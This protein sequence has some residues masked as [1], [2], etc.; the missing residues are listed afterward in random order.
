MGWRC[1]RGGCRAGVKRP[2]RGDTFLFEQFLPMLGK[3]GLTGAEIRRLT[4]ENPA[5]AFT[6]RRRPKSGQA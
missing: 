5:R 3:A 4:Q 1:R 6:V 2:M